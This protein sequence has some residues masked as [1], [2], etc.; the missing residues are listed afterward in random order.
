MKDARQGDVKSH[1]GVKGEACE[2]GRRGPISAC[3]QG[4][5]RQLALPHETQE[6]AG[7]Q[8]DVKSDQLQCGQS[9]CETGVNSFSVDITACKSGRRGPTSACD[10]GGQWQHTLSFLQARCKAGLNMKVISFRAVIS[11]CV[12]GGRWQQVL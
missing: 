6:D 5:Q 3:K 2:M 7:S 4:G 8:D 12:K 11:A 10:A 1:S 9:A